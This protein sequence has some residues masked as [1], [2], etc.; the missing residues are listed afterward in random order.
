MTGTAPDS[1]PNSGR[2]KAALDDLVRFDTQN[3]PGREREAAGLVLAELQAMGCRAEAVEFEPGRVNVAGIFEN[4]PGPTFA[5]NTHLDVVPAGDGWTSDPF[6]LREEGARLFARGA[7][8]AKGPLVAMLEAM[9][10]LIAGRAGWSGTLIGV[11]VADEETQSRGAKAYRETAPAIDYCVIGEPTSLTTVTAHKGSLRP[12][13]QVRGATAHSGIPDAGVNAILKSMPL[14]R[15]IEAEHGRLK[16]GPSHPLVGHPSLTVTRA[17]GGH[18]DNIVPDSCTFGL[19]RRMVPGED[20]AAVRRS[21]EALVDRAAGEAGTAMEI[22]EWKPTTGPATETDAGHP[23]VGAAQHACH[24]HNGR[25]TPLS[26][27]LGGCDLV[28]FRAI[29]AQGVVIG[30]GSIDVAHKPD[31]FVPEE[32][33][34]RAV[35]IYEDVAR[36]MLRGAGPFPASLGSGT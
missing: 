31:E 28:H 5:F 1:M 10:R 26:G 11:F 24:H 14:L 7:C 17:N 36:H 22:V 2:L 13:V 18:A 23:I 35:L 29:G 27:F 3:P 20:E 30:P 6:R 25:E 8:D 12:I 16:S 9:R 32:E 33:L 21:L 15:L 34:V 4:G 19:D